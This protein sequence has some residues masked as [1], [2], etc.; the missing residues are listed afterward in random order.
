VLPNPS[1]KL[2]VYHSPVD[3]RKSYRSLCAV[4]EQELSRNA[5]S[6]DAFIFINR[7]KTLAK[8]LWWDR[9]GWCLLL[10]RLSA[11]RFRVS[12]RGEVK[13]LELG[14]VRIFFDGL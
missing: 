13:Q 9:T 14:N 4:V 2:W 5:Q 6:G 8:V 7:A 3:L 12:S 10:K 1:G 11:G